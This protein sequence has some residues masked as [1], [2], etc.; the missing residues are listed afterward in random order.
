MLGVVTS[1]YRIDTSIPAPPTECK[2]GSKRFRSG[3]EFDDN[4]HVCRCQDGVL[5]CN[6][7]LL[8]SLPN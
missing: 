6:D 1:G 5:T 7:N 8:V 4:C 2:L 3:F